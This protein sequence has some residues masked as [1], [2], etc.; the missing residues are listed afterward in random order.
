MMIILIFVRPFNWFQAVTAGAKP[1]SESSLFFWLVSIKLYCYF[2]CQVFRA[3]SIVI[4]LNRTMDIASFQLVMVCF[5]RLL[6]QNLNI[7]VNSV[8]ERDTISWN[9]H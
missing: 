8:L 4:L 5:D 2:L 7:L 9:E 3:L 1:C 6:F